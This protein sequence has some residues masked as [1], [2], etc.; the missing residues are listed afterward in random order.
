M[1]R[2][3]NVNFYNTDAI[4]F[5]EDT[6]ETYCLIIAN[7]IL[8]QVYRNLEGADPIL[9]IIS[10]KCEYFAFESP[11]NHTTMKIGLPEIYSILNRHF[12]TVRLLFVYDAY[13]TATEQFCLLF[14]KP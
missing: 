13:S 2:Y 6:D 5:L 11:V 4:R 10:N 8:H 7:S 9:D 12:K 3:D 14:L 1:M